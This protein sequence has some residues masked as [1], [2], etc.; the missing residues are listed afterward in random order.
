MK[1]ID[2]QCALGTRSKICAAKYLERVFSDM[3]MLIAVS[4]PAL[5]SIPHIPV[6][7]SVVEVLPFSVTGSDERQADAEAV[8]MHL[9][10]MWN[11]CDQRFERKMHRRYGDIAETQEKCWANAQCKA[12]RLC[13]R[14]KVE[15]HHLKMLL[16]IVLKEWWESYV[17]VWC[18]VDWTL[19]RE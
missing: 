10:H 5:E 15:V 6:G 11:G 14:T 3:T 12:T 18:S 9:H 2:L 17:V 16:D 8:G 19:V 7:S 13:A 4:G 1:S